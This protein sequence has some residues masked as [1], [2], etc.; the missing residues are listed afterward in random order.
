MR[1]ATV[2]LESDRAWAM[3]DFMAKDI[4]RIELSALIK[5]YRRQKLI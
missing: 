4:G 3:K 2:E 5:T 1:A